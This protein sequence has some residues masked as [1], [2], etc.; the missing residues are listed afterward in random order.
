MNATEKK[1]L[2]ARA[3]KSGLN[4][5]IDR[6]LAGTHKHAVHYTFMRSPDAFCLAVFFNERD[7]C[8]WLLG[9]ESHV[10]FMKKPWRTDEEIAIASTRR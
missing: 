2:I 5:Y 3:K 8:T 4:L 10:K 9:F 7:A 1:H 6:C